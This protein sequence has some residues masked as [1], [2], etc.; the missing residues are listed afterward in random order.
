MKKWAI[1][2]IIT[3]I[4]LA[5]G[6]LLLWIVAG[7]LPVRYIETPKY[8]VVSSG[9]DYEVRAYAPQIV[10]EVTKQGE[11]RQTQ[12]DGFRDVAGYIFGSNKTKASISMTAPVLHQPDNQSEKIA[13][14]APVLHEPGTAPATYKLA[15]VMPS[16]YTLDTLP[17]PNNPNVTLRQVPARKCAALVFRGYAEEATVLQKTRQLLESLKADGMV[18][19]G[20]PFLAQYHPPWTMPLMRR[21][22]ILV[23]V[24]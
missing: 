2:T 19:T 1:M 20:V 8:E 14:T 17:M 3:I 11:Y 13:M 16:S 5:A 4:G 15:F 21:N 24:K 6:L 10:A 9:K 7:Y 22:E 12:N 18:T 23:E